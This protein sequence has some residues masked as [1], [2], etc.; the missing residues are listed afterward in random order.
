VTGSIKPKFVG[1][2]FQIPSAKDSN[3]IAAFNQPLDPAKDFSISGEVTVPDARIAAAGLYVT[4]VPSNEVINKLG[5]RSL[6]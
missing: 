3:A 2:V 1:P 6:Q 4:D 5:T